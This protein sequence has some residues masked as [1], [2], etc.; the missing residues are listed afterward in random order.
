VIYV[1][2]CACMCVC[3]CVCVCE[4]VCVCVCICVCLPLCCVCDCVSVSMSVSV[5]VSVSVFVVRSPHR[6]NKNFEQASETPKKKKICRS[7]LQR[8]LSNQIHVLLKLLQYAILFTATW[9]LTLLQPTSETSAT[10]SWN[11]CNTFRAPLSLSLS[12]TH[13]T[14]L[15]RR[16]YTLKRREKV[17]WGGYD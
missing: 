5:S 16:Q 1:C 3:V 14:A 13:A 7:V 17:I 6:Q 10:H 15:Q 12:L 9:F 8:T 2:V 4:C 11:H